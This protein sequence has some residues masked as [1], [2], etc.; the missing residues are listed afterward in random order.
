MQKINEFIIQNKNKNEL[1]YIKKRLI[2]D[3]TII[4]Q[5]ITQIIIRL[6]KIAK[7]LKKNFINCRK[8]T[9]MLFLFS[10]NAHRNLK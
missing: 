2:Q 6:L 9:T 1:L 8:I 5:N 3:L 4:L 7:Y 10:L